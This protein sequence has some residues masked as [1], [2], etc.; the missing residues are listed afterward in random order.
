MFLF[1]YI[2]VWMYL[3]INLGKTAHRSTKKCSDR[4]S[5]FQLNLQWND[6]VDSA[7]ALNDIF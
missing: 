6:N 3:T 1:V 5:N 4:I 7:R 2:F